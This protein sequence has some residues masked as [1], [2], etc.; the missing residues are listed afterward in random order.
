MWNESSYF[1]ITGVFRY[2]LLMQNDS[3]EAT[4][5]EP[6]RNADLIAHG[7]IPVDLPAPVS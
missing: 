1:E 7:H 6:F 3:N 5:S 2:K 4:S